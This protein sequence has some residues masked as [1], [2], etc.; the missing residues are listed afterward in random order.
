MPNFRLAAVGAFVLGGVLLFAV[1]IFLIGSRRMLFDDTFQVHAEF[2]ELA[3]LENGATVRVAGMDAGEVETI[4]VPAS[5]SGRFRVRMR[6][7][8]DLHQLVRLDSVASIQND[9]LVGNK[10]VQV[11]AGSEQTGVV[12]DEGTIQSQE[13]FDIADMMEQLSSTIDTVNQTIVTLRGELETALTT[14]VDTATSAQ[15]L[16]T[17]VGA[18]TRTIMASGQKVTTDLQTIVAGVRAGRGTVGRLV[19]DDALFESAK[20]LAADA[21]KT[22]AN[23]RDASAQARAAIEDLRNK[24]GSVDS[25]T[26]N[27][28]QTLIQARDAMSDM[29]E[30]T[31]ALKRSFFFRGFFN[32]RG[33]YDLDEVGV[34]EYR[35]GALESGD[36][37]SVRIWLATAVLF[38]TDGSGAEA[39][40]D[41]GKLRLDSAMSTFVRYPRTTPFVVEGY[42]QEAMGSERF[43]QSRRRAELVRSYLVGKFGIDPNYT[44]T[45]PMGAEAEGSPDGDRWDGVALAVFPERAASG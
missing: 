7:R 5:P 12:P 41:E 29:A 15:T 28:N 21:E 25:V 17:D 40:T 44:I 6:V 11:Q 42:A 8:E 20:S 36:R 35:T 10:F 18:D 32:R 24:G 31:E 27:L 19:T 43:L 13:P 34:R 26:S 9:G 4:E 23:V 1:G 14:L 38:A 39:L 2:A 45:M 16:I 33:Y 30:N 3:A 37:K 22:M